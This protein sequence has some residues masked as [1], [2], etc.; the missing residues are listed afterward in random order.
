MLAAFRESYSSGHLASPSSAS[1]C[2]IATS[3]E[4]LGDEK[5]VTA[6]CSQWVCLMFKQ[7]SGKLHVGNQETKRCFI[8]AFRV[9]IKF[10]CS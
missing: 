2:G 1:R 9:C 7:L 10:T 6:H 4:G 8:M 5:L 3:P